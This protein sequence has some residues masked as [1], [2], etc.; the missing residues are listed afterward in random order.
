MRPRARIVILVSSVLGLLGG[1]DPAEPVVQASDRSL[2]IEDAFVIDM[3]G[4]TPPVEASVLVVDGLIAGVGPLEDLEIP[5]GT[6]RLDGSGRFL[7]PGLTDAHVHLFD[8]NDLPV[9]LA[10]GITSVL[11]MSGAALH[12]DWRERIERGELIGPALFTTGPQLKVEADPP[13]DF[14]RGVASAGA[15]ARL[16]AYQDEVGY[17]F[18]KVWGPLDPTSYDAVMQAASARGIRVLGHIPRD[19]GLGPVLEAGQS[20]IAHLEELFNKA[21]GREI[22]DARIPEVVAPVRSAGVPVITTLVTYEAIAGSVAEDPTPLLE[23]D[24]RAWLDPVRQTLWEPEFNRYRTSNRIGRDDE[25]RAALGFMGRIAAAL[26]EAGV[27]LI[28]GSD[29]GEIPGLVPGVDLH[30]EL[31]LLVEAGLTEYEA[32]RTATRNAGA[33]LDPHVGFGTIEVGKRG[34]LVLLD[35]NPLEALS[36]LENPAGVVTRGRWISRVDIEEMLAEVRGINERTGVFARIL[37]QQG[38]DAAEA[39]V[40]GWTGDERPFAETPALF[41]AFVMARKGDLEGGIRVARLVASVYPE[42]YMPR[43]ILGV[44][45]LGAGRISEGRA[46]LEEVLALVP[47]HDA[48]IAWLERT[49]G[50][51]SSESSP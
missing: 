37:L 20:S 30:R 27:P 3:V 16:V 41:L 10:H 6:P 2:V 5:A 33:F 48:A 8:A 15:A 46:A 45:L 1:T 24:A 35:G 17:D 28:A 39:Y 25:Y 18:I 38:V 21:L 42:S 14:E 11:N 19:V 47:G 49:G 7:M 4:E 51:S 31:E 12:L 13:V 23:R 9:L 29:A 43:F 36:N 26:H 50:D 32:L 34:D 22:D 40:T 44:G